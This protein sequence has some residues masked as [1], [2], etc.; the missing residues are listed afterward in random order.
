VKVEVPGTEPLR[1]V[2]AVGTSPS[3]KAWNCD[4]V[5]KGWTALAAISA[6]AIPEAMP[7]GMG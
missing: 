1:P 7:M 3:Q 4:Q 5:E 6:F 2:I